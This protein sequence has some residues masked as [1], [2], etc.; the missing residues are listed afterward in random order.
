[1]LVVNAERNKSGAEQVVVDALVNS[2]LPG[3]AVSGCYIPHRRGKGAGEAD[4]LVVTPNS[5]TVVEVKGLRERV[6]G[7]LSCPANSR[8]SLPGVAGDPVHVR[9]G[10]TNP[11]D[12]VG[13][14]LYDL[15]H[16]VEGLGGDQ[17]ISG[18]VA[19]VPLPGYPVTLNSGALPTGRDVR[20]ATPDADVASWFA[21]GPH[22][23]AAVWTAELVA[24]MLAQLRVTGFSEGEL[25]GLGFPGTAEPIVPVAATGG[26][27]KRDWVPTGEIPDNPTR[28]MAMGT[29]VSWPHAGLVRPAQPHRRSRARQTAATAAAI[30][31]VGSVLWF[32]VDN[33]HSGSSHHT[34]GTGTSA[35]D[36]AA[37]AP[38]APAPAAAPPPPPA[39]APRGDSGPLST[40]PMGDPSTICYPFQSGC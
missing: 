5:C 2:S 37:P 39:P 29:E 1:M 26:P 3:I 10:D 34:T 9:T 36:P 22:R 31:V 28:A 12:Q 23:R 21:G 40:F 33:D 35:A 19:V 17:F 7:E 38:A 8:W 25:V 13:E 30:A 32:A 14:R 16:L 4:L 20:L 15:K 6:S 18:L 24:Q 11:L 27:T